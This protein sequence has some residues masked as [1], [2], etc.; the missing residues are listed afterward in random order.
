MNLVAVQFLLHDENE[1]TLILS[2][3]VD[4]CNCQVRH[5]KSILKIILH[6]KILKWLD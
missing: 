1:R 3:Y 2:Y 5:S 6:K 4:S